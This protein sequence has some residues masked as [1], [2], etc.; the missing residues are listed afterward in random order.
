MSPPE[1]VLYGHDGCCLCDDARVILERVR[2][3]HPFA[4]TEVDIDGDERLLRAY[5]ERIPVVTIDGDEAFELFVDESELTR[6]LAQSHGG[7]VPARPTCRTPNDVAPGMA[8]PDDR[9]ATS[10]DPRAARCTSGPASSPG[11][12]RT[13]PSQAQRPRETD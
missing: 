8:D 4:L 7:S 13:S 1:V 11:A 6:R 2:N 10:S 5:L 3:A 9:Q 12:P